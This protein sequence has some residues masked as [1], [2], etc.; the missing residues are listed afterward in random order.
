[1]QKL[2]VF[3]SHSRVVGLR[4]KKVAEFES[5]RFN[6]TGSENSLPSFAQELYLKIISKL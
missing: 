5:K 3:W 4:P 1:M 2:R 6:F